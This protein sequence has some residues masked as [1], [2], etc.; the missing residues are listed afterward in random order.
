MSKF[1]ADVLQSGSCE[2][3]HNIQEERQSRYSRCCCS[4]PS[5]GWF[6]GLRCGIALAFIWLS[7][8]VLLGKILNISR[9]VP[10]EMAES[11]NQK[12]PGVQSIRL[13][14]I[15]GFVETWPSLE[16]R[17]EKPTPSGSQKRA[18]CRLKGTGALR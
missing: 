6:C 11:S 13:S 4:I 3:L 16:I 18:G 15:V 9:S 2:E 14:L 10:V 8:C 17:I 7:I 1:L 5:L 12:Y